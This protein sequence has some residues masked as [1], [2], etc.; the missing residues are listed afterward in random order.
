MKEGITLNG[1]FYAR[2]HLDQFEQTA[3][4]DAERA[5]Y[6][7]IISFLEDWFSKNGYIYVNTSG[8]TGT[9]KPIR[10]QKK[11]MIN[12]A[13]LTCDFFSL[14]EHDSI[15]LCMPVRY[16]AG[17]MMLV[18]AIIAQLNIWVEVP[19]GRP[20]ACFNKP[21][22]FAAM[23]PL[24]VFNSLQYAKDKERLQA[25]SNLLIGGGAIDEEMAFELKLFPNQVYSS[26]GM[27]ETVSHIAMRKLNGSDVLNRYY[28]L[29]SV[30]LDK[31]KEDTLIIKAP[32]VSDEVLKTH[33]LVEFYEDG[34]FRVL[35]RLDNMINSG[36][37]KI[38][39]EKVEE[40]LQNLID[41]PYVLS[42]RKDTR[43]GEALTLLIQSEPYDTTDLINK[44]KTVLTAYENPKN[45]FF[46]DH[47]PMTETKKI[48]RAECKELANKLYKQFLDQE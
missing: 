37:V 23:V 34:G 46:T 25:V 29:K 36:G 26:Y 11:H 44:M 9:P 18:R 38:Q 41:T 31:S 32:L 45:I 28:P 7:E 20:F 22:E 12:S 6:K 30:E 13:R 21:L 4:N 5:Y 8:S 2:N 47:I 19:S 15:L 24:Q 33:D 40:K 1:A 35:G 14:K 10:V 27:T 17:K 39:V 43:L 3:K 16:I 42:S 48:R